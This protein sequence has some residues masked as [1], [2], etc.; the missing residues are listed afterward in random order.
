MPEFNL[1]QE[2][3]GSIVALNADFML[4]LWVN[5]VFSY[6]Q[7]V[8]AILCFPKGKFYSFYYSITLIALVTGPI[9]SIER[10]MV[11]DYTISRLSKLVI[12]Y[13]IVI[14]FYAIGIHLLLKQKYLIFNLIV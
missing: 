6:V 11:G 13:I 4:A 8:L 1:E 9:Y 14:L 7:I 10:N 12:F 2:A 5:S 3:G